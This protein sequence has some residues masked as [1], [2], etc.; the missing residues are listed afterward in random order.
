MNL[1][2]AGGPPLIPAA[3]GPVIPVPPVAAAVPL[4]PPR[5]NKKGKILRKLLRERPGLVRKLLRR[6]LKKKI[7]PVLPAVAVENVLPQKVDTSE[8]E[9]SC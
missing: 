7:V 3:G 2:V 6:K 5:S 8:G 9:D 1:I 4:A